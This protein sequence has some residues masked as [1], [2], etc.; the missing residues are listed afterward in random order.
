MGKYGVLI[1]LYKKEKPKYDALQL[2][3]RKLIGE[4]E[5]KGR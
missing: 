4:H 2:Y 1:A 3:A 5:K